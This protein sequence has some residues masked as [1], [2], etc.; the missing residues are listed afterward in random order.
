MLN[1]ITAD[2]ASQRLDRYLKTICRGVPYARLMRALREGEVRVN[3]KKEAASYRLREGDE[4]KVPEFATPHAH[5]DTTPPKIL[6]QYNFDELVLYEDQDMVVLNKPAGLA[7]Q[8][9]SKIMHSLDRLVQHWRPQETLRLT[10]RLDRDTS[11]VLLLAK[12]LSSARHLTAA[13]KAG[14]IDKTYV[15]VCV[16]RP[17]KDKGSIDKAIKKL[18]GKL[19]ER[20]VTD[21]EGLSAVTEYHILKHGQNHLTLLSL[22]PLTGRTHQL[23]V[24]CMALGC[25]ILGDGKYAGRAAQYL[26]QRYP[27]HLHAASVRFLHPHGGMMTIEAPLPPHMEETLQRHF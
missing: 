26:D 16:G 24:H 27:L 10:H 22:H 6:T 17:E 20:M 13:F 15:A 8:G 11:G 7:V 9:G 19:G 3:G 23:R 25:P 5:S 2:Q 1:L 4:V 14:K 21:P 12:H 18:P